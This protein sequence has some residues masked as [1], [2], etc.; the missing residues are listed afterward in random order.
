[1]CDLVMCMLTENFFGQMAMT[2]NE[3]QCQ[4]FG[5]WC[6]PQLGNPHQNLHQHQATLEV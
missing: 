2:I 4:N 1:M 6:P 5:A 3:T